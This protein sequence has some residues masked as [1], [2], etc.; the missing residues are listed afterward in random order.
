M[1]ERWGCPYTIARRGLVG[2]LLRPWHRK[3]PITVHLDRL[4]FRKSELLHRHLENAFLQSRVEVARREEF[5]V[6]ERSRQIGPQLSSQRIRPQILKLHR[7]GPHVFLWHYSNF[8]EALAVLV[9]L[10]PCV[11]VR[12]V[13][14]RTVTR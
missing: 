2:T 3:F 7:I 13:A 12:I 1:H 14:F 5:L 11:R 9:G 10:G 8:K 6:P 4:I